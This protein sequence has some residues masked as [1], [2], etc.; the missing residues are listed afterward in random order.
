MKP[1]ALI[2]VFKALYGCCVSSRKHD[3]VSDL[4]AVNKKETWLEDDIRIL[5]R[6]DNSSQYIIHN[7]QQKYRA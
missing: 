5:E 2:L 4:S 1:I 3:K 6:A 7:K